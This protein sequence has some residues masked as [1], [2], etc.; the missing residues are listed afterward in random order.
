[1]KK[2]L[3]I[4][5]CLLP[6]IT[7]S[8]FQII[9]V[10]PT[11]ATCS[12]GTDGTLTVNTTGG[13]NPITYDIGSGPQT[14]NVF[15]G[16]PCG[17]YT[18]IA[19]DATMT[20]VTG[21]GTVS[22]PSPIISS[23]FTVSPSCNG[24]CDGILDLT[25]TGGTPPYIV[26][27]PFGSMT[28]YSSFTSLF[29]YC[30]GTYTF[31]IQDANGCTDVV[32][33]TFTEPTPIVASVTTTDET[34]LGACDGTATIIATGGVTPYN[35]SWN[36]CGSGSPITQ[37]G[38][39]IS[40]LCVGSYNA[41]VTDGNGCTSTPSCADVNT[42][43]N[44]NLVSTTNEIPSTCNNSCDA[45][46]II[47]TNGGTLP[48]TVT[49]P[50]GV[51]VT[52]SSVV[53]LTGYCAG[54]YT[55]LV[56]DAAGCSEPVVITFT[57]PPVLSVSVSTTDETSLGACDGTATSMVSGGASPYTYVWTD[58]GTG[59]TIG[60]ASTETNLCAGS[61]QVE[62]TDMNG[63]SASSS[64]E[65]VGTSSACN[66]VSTMQTT[67]ALCNGSCDGTVVLFTT[68]GTLPYTVND[69]M[70]GNVV[71]YTSAQTFANI[72][73]GT[74]TLLIEDA[75]S[76]TETYNLVITEPTEVVHSVTVVDESS[77]GSCDGSITVTATGGAPGY[78]YS[79]NCSGIIQASPT[80]T[81]LCAGTYGVTAIDANGCAS[82]CNSIG[83]T[84]GSPT[85]SCNLVSTMQTTDAFCNGSCDGTVVLFTTGG[86]LPYT[87]N[88]PMTGNIV[89]YTSA[90]TFGNICP[91]TYTL[92]IEDAASCT[93]TYNLV[94]TEP[95]E[96][97]H[98]VTVVDESSL[99]S[100]DGSITV[101]ATGGAPGYMYSINCSGIIQASPTFTGLC[102]GTYG[103]TAI[104]VNGCASYCESA[105]D[106]VSTESFV[107]IEMLANA[108][109]KVYPNPANAQ[110]TI[111]SIENNVDV[112]IFSISG[113]L[114]YAVENI[115]NKNIDVSE[116]AKGIY[117]LKLKADSGIIIKRL[118]IE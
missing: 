17:S 58:C 12:G 34:S 113:K 118:V 19:Y 30:A 95:T 3:L 116:W 2:L 81:G 32:V 36:D 66:M 14:S 92:L 87:V 59:Q 82:Y 102:A 90:Q 22:C 93:E 65:T 43:A 108:Q 85:S 99:G 28:S 101:T 73:P 110:V 46:T 23:A 117:V 97:V 41:V 63:C 51:I 100:C 1:M 103:V 86:T 15:T 33:A 47:A 80:F 112:T 60:T 6:F 76:C 69:P 114:I 31:L 24:F 42:V 70:T 26:T 4:A 11:D 62:V 25:T 94:I 10:V 89:T 5:F 56:E 74:Y 44:C 71:T 109:V 61:Y 115:T 21:T 111:E 105:G 88:D 57:E 50:F 75:A 72:C 55:F 16:L 104:D 54:T 83:D 107:G 13:V 45:T 29:G 18:V 84:I 68:G 91:G 67:D 48:Y 7:F 77:L 27:D 9:S 64:C 79:I 53:T 52:Y 8:Q 96:V 106:T 37:F 38:G 35:Y 20:T 49:D 98:S 39:T 78:M 40:G